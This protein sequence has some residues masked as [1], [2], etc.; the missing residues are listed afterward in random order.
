M[1]HYACDRC[2]K[3]I[4]PDEE[5]RYVVRMEVQATM[6]PVENDVESDHLLEM[7]EIL[8]RLEDAENE[9]ICDDV[10]RRQRFDLCSDCHRM[11]VANPLGVDSQ[12]AFQ[13]S[14]N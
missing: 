4:D 12:V 5:I 7:H 6:E 2:K 8:E 11:F 1:I 9:D 14:E 13:F 3:I 10:Y